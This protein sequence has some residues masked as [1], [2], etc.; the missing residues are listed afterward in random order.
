M[1]GSMS[2][3]VP[4]SPGQTTTRE[5]RRW[6]WL[7]RA[8]LYGLA[9]SALIHLLIVLLA[10][11]ITVRFS[12]GDAGGQAG[13][14]GV[15]FA[16]LNDDSLSQ[17]NSPVLQTERT[18]VQTSLSDSPM[19]LDLL[20]DRAEDRSVDDLSESIAPALEPGG[21][22]LTSIDSETGSAGAGS[23]EGSSFF[24][25]EA[26]GRR[27][28]YIVDISGSMNSAGDNESTRWELT[29]AELARSVRSLEPE[30]EFHIQLFSSG[31]QS[32]FGVASWSKATPVNKRLTA[33]ALATVSPNGGTEPMPG[34]HA[35][36]ALDPRA[37]AIYFMSD[38]EVADGPGFAAALR[39]L[40]GRRPV[41][42]N[43]VLFGDAGGGDTLR[44]VEAMMKNIAAQSGGRY[45]RVG[46][47][48][49]P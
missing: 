16:V 14:E 38:G 27:F 10:A 7:E 22:G 18:A 49:R 48:G 6:R 30:T 44:R 24:G 26:K 43:C 19:S 1:W 8:T 11:L 45:I 17:D 13:N 47:G 20:A 9:G 23:G 12:F 21:G 37:D 32:L 3:A 15:E 5:R 35:V 41:P 28:G 33:D 34:F 36:F 42:I 25:L 2:E 31:S 29:R 39:A 46:A 4:T 40:N